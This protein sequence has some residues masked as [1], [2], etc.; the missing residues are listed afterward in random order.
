MANHPEAGKQYTKEAY[1]ELVHQLACEIAGSSRNQ[2]DC[3]LGEYEH[4]GGL[5][6]DQ[7][8]AKMISYGIDPMMEG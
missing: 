2:R 1:D 8:A 5:S 4:I 7:I 6:E 3:V